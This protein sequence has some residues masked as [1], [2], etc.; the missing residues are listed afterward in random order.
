MSDKENMMR[1]EI[2][3]LLAVILSAKYKLSWVEDVEDLI[4]AKNEILA[5]I[6]KLLEYYDY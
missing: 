4:D 3:G 2:T 6:D 1:M 5:E